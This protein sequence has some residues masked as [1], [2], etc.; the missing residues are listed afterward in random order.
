MIDGLCVALIALVGALG[1]YAPFCVPSRRLMILG[2]RQG[3]IIILGAVECYYGRPRT[4][5][6]KLRPVPVR[7]DPARCGAGK[8]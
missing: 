7:A 5:P 1:A 3:L 8:N 4:L 6:P 2:I